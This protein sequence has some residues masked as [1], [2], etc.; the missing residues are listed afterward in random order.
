MLGRLMK[1][2]FKA[3][4]R[5]FF[6]LYLVL[7]CISVINRFTLHLSMDEGLIQIITNFFTSVQII[8]S[9]AILVIT[10]LFMI[11][12]FYK[13]LLSSEG[14]LMFTLPVK[15]HELI[16]SKLLM[17][18]FWFFTSLMAVLISLFIVFGTMDNISLFI[19]AISTTF[20]ALNASF[21][22]NWVLLCIEFTILALLSLTFNILLVYIAIAVGQLFTKQKLV[23]SFVSYAVFYMA[24][25][26]FLLIVLATSGYFIF[27]DT[28]LI[29]TLPQVAFPIVIL[30]V[31]IGC[32]VSYGA[33]YHI[34][35]KKLNLD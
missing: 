31:F 18:L 13:N 27:Q 33:T 34:L 28:Y 32:I 22:G 1:H 25:Q 8:L 17:T 10:V 9:I 24:I 19:E 16:L 14:Y 23:A 21:G 4:S 30:T 7:V 5:I 12:R 2:E 15:T 20:E 35:D 29:S 6:P 26:L 11:I 3:T